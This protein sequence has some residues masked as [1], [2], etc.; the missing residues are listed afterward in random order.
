MFKKI[1][2]FLLTFFFLAGG[3]VSVFRVTGS[4]VAQAGLH[5]SM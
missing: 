4:H 1:L 5:L 2:D 3:L